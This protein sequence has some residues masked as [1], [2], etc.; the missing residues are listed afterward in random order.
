MTFIDELRLRVERVRLECERLKVASE[1]ARQNEEAKAEE[2]R[3][4]ERI[5]AAEGGTGRVTPPIPPHT[6]IVKIDKTQR[7]ARIVKDAGA[8]GVT[9]REVRDAFNKQGFELSLNYVFNILSRLKKTGTV[10][11][12]EG[13]YYTKS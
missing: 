3:A 7:C 9:P 12:R 4:W 8:V 11:Q 10:E 6:V 2:L 5:F 1:T 13:R